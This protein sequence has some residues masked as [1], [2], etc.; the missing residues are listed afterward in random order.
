MSDFSGNPVSLTFSGGKE[1]KTVSVCSAA[2]CYAALLQNPDFLTGS[3]TVSISDG[4]AETAKQCSDLCAFLQT[5]L[6]SKQ[7]LSEKMDAFNRNLDGIEP[8]FAKSPD[9]KW[10]MEEFARMNQ[11]GKYIRGALVNIGYSLF[12]DRPAD[13]SDDLALAFELFQT[14]ILI[15]DDIIDHAKLRRNQITIHENYL[16]QWDSMDIPQNALCTDTA[17]S[18]ALLAGDV[19]L[20][21]ANLRLC[22]AY[23]DSPLLGKISTYFYRTILKTSCG[24][25]IDVALPFYEQNQARGEHDITAD[26]LNIY[27]LKTAWYTLTGPLCLGAQLAE[28][29]DAQMHQLEQFAEALGIAFQIKD[30][31]IGIYGNTETGKDIGSDI[32]EFKQTLLYAYTKTTGSHYDELMQYYGKSALTDSDLAAV[33]EI[34]RQSGALR[35]AE[36][37]MNGYFDTARDLLKK[38]DFLSEEK[39]SVLY[40]LTLFMNLRNK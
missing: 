12:T 38:I 36:Q 5:Y 7:R 39:K 37:T 3:C 22:E 14:A 15:H 13:Y 35:Y 11:A 29:P 33:R 6:C 24:E 32:S 1:A 21:L 16:R 20:Y 40:G 23:A 4:D 26:I 31:I 30:D 10:I 9:A 25:I 34:F 18:L 28:C 19:G 27:R 8:D 17:N 2:E